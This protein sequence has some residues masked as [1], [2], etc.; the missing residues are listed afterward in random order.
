MHEKARSDEPVEIYWAHHVSLVGAFPTIIYVFAQCVSTRP[1]HI[2]IVGIGCSTRQKGMLSS[3][4]MP[5]SNSQNIVTAFLTKDM[6]RVT[7]ACFTTNQLETIIFMDKFLLFQYQKT[8]RI[9]KI[10]AV[11]SKYCI[12]IC[13]SFFPFSR[14]DYDGSAK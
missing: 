9:G 3:V 12:S 13:L 6:L 11:N 4:T 2:F 8:Y 1:T 5:F 7:D 14:I 10:N